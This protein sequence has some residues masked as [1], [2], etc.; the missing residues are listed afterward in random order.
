MRGIYFCLI[1]ILLA[2]PVPAG[3]RA[4]V[5]ADQ[6]VNATDTV[7]LANIVAGNLDVANYDLA[8][9]V[10]VAAQGGDFT[11]P[12]DAAEW[13]AAQGPGDLNRFVILITPGV[14]SIP[15]EIVLPSYT[16]VLGYGYLVSR[17]IRTAG[18]A[19]TR[20]AYCSGKTHITLHDLTLRNEAG[21]STSNHVLRVDG[22]TSVDLQGV[23]YESAGAT[24]TNYQLYIEGNSQLA[25]RDLLFRHD[26]GARVH[27]AVEV[28]TSE[29][30]MAH[31]TILMVSQSSSVD[32]YGVF[33]MGA[34]TVYLRDSTIAMV[35]QAAN[36]FAYCTFLS[37][38]GGTMQVSNS[39]LQ[40]VTL[41]A[42]NN[43]YYGSNLDEHTAKYFCCLLDGSTTT[44]GGILTRFGCYNSSGVAVP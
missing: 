42:G 19:D 2:A 8:T 22:S 37:G 35:H 26:A 39:S 27:R 1:V 10:V 34:S 7:L 12:V 29:V 9:V 24:G 25:G 20:V 32:I 17:I 14:Y 44:Y 3:N 21:G 40:P 18:G 30:S 23:A 6:A 15:E 43:R 38:V 16:S 11:S 33:V 28:E 13:V 41:T 36:R 5:N 31:A 4:D